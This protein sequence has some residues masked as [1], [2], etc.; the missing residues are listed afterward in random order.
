VV[1]AHLIISFALTAV[2]LFG[3]VAR[4]CASNSELVF[5]FEGSELSWCRIVFCFETALELGGVEL[6]KILRIPGRVTGCPCSPALTTLLGMDAMAPVPPDVPWA[7]A[8]CV[9]ASKEA[10]TNAERTDLE[11]M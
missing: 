2:R 6:V 11:S 1:L 7:A 5:Y 4:I 10:M 8:G 3:Q 9:E